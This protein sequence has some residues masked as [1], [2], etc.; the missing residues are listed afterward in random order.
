LEEVG[1]PLCPDGFDH[2][3]G[4]QRGPAP[5]ANSQHRLCEV[6]RSGLEGV[7]EGRRPFSD[8]SRLQRQVR[9]IGSR[10]SS[11]TTSFKSIEIQVNVSIQTQC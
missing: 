10:R 2:E 1:S 8:H 6:I 11:L 7:G 3:M 9:K 5:T 4:S